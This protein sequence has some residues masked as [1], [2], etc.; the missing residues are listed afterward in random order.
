MI[1]HL[2]TNDP[3]V[4]IIIITILLWIKL[5]FP[6]KSGP[7]SIALRASAGRQSQKRPLKKSEKAL[8]MPTFSKLKLKCLVMS[9]SDLLALYPLY[10]M[11]IDTYNKGRTGEQCPPKISKLPPKYFMADMMSAEHFSTVGT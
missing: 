6:K 11:H 1:G 9:F 4:V 10:F 5:D 2:Y 7:G 8:K 3:E